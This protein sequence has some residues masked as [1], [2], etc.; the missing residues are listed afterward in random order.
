M[1]LIT[2]T[3]GDGVISARFCYS[4]SD[5]ING[6]KIC[7]SLLSK[8]SAVSGCK[9]MHQFGGYAE[10]APDH[11]RSLMNGD[12]WNFSFKYVFER[13]APVNVSWG[14]MG[15]FLK[16]KDGQTVEVFNEPLK[17]LNGTTKNRKKLSA[18]EPALR[19]I[20]HPLSWEQ[21]AET[22]DLS[23][24]FKISGFSSETQNKV[25]S[26]FK[27]LIERCDLKGILSNHGVEVCFEKD[28]QN[29]GE[30][31]YELL[32]K[33]DKVKIRASQYTG[34]FYGL[35]SLLQLL[36]TYNA[37]IPCGKI[38]DLPQFSWRGQHL[39]CARHFYKVDSVLRLLDLMAFLKLNRFHWHMIDDESFRL[40]LTSFPELADKTGMRGNG[41]VI[42]AVFGGGMG[43][44]GGTY[45]A[46]DVRRIIDHASSLGIS[47]MP[48]I[49]I[50]AHSLALI[51]VIPEMRDSE[52]RS[53]EESVQGYSE[54]TI[55]PAMPA[56]W[57]F[58]G[59][60]IP[61]VCILFPFGVIHL[62][63][64]E[65]PVKLWKK[66]PAI[67]KLKK[68]EGLKTTE[69]VL[70]WTMQK[71]AKILV[72]AGGRPAAWEE[73]GRGQN[74]GIGNDALLFSWTGLEPGL[75]AARKGYE[76]VMCPAQHV[77]FDMAH[78]SEVY[79]AGVSW[80]AFISIADALE[81]EPVPVEE[82]EL[83]QRVIGIQGGLWSET[84][85]RDRDMESMLAPRILALSEGA[86]STPSRKRKL[87]E[88]MGAA[89][90][91]E[92][93]FDQLDWECHG[94]V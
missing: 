37:L 18:E 34:Y 84:I 52:D 72:E 75:K 9:L 55:N 91:F 35:I 16:L 23:E 83:V 14:P 4:G 21:E 27:S 41:C 81:W 62:G 33:P 58:L 48:E 45:S 15:T 13:H 79:E 61:E 69:D 51:K 54:N 36:K 47:V 87:T 66:S 10:L 73:A 11:T 44:T 28:K 85:I 31:G 74:G 63:C 5:E 68:K 6:F 32:I 90:Y 78:S 43:P 12:E 20:P 93:I 56:T 26:S 7:F 88:F 40:E 17:F 39:D 89:R 67:E 65:L 70:E 80:A 60:V 76:V 94:L 86:W 1:R 71:V 38:K 57:E 8:C 22:C 64:D 59:K 19:L 92:K 82:A 46:D 42:P 49:E 2:E 30:E 53:C 29:F 50:P 3:D 77:Y 25:V 24:G